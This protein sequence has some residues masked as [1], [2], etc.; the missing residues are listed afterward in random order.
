MQPHG[1]I[2]RNEATFILSN[3]YGDPSIAKYRGACQ[4]LPMTTEENI[5]ALS[6]RVTDAPENSKEFQAVMDKLRANVKA[7]A[8]R[9]RER[10]AAMQSVLPYS[11]DASSRPES[12]HG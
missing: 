11:E 6:R 1:T 9:E 7:R 12:L 10:V 4:T 8:A 2:I 3:L 5:R